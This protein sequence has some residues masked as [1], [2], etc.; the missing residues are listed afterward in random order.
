MPKRSEVYFGTE[1]QAQAN[2]TADHARRRKFKFYAWAD[3]P[4]DIV[5]TSASSSKKVCKV[6]ELEHDTQPVSKKEV[7][8]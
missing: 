6:S 3:R 7:V 8:T 4:E 2:T 1:G 5:W